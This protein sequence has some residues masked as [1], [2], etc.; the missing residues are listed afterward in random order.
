VRVLCQHNLDGVP[1]ASYADVSV[2]SFGSF[3]TLSTNVPHG[4]GEGLTT[5][6]GTVRLIP[7]FAPAIFGPPP[8]MLDPFDDAGWSGSVSE[9]SMPFWGD[10]SQLYLSAM[11]AL[12][13]ALCPP[14]RLGPPDPMDPLPPVFLARITGTGPR[15]AYRAEAYVNY[16]NTN[17]SSAP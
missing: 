14:P 10:Y 8:P 17:T 6:D 5:T 2:S 9:T 16:C 15:G 13:L 7:G 11:H 3:S 4:P 12:P 1:F